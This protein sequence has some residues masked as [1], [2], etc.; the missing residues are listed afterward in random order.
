MNRLLLA[1]ALAAVGCKSGHGLVNL[2]V[3]TQAGVSLTGIDHLTVRITDQTRTPPRQATPFDVGVANGA[4]PP[5]QTIALVFGSDVNGMVAIAVDAVRANGSIAAQASLTTSVSPFH[6]SSLTLSLPGAAV[7]DLGSSGD[8][9]PLDLAVQCPSIVGTNIGKF[10]LRKL[11]MPT[12]RPDWAIDLDGDGRPDNQFG[13]LGGALLAQN[14]N[15]QTS[16]DQQ[17]AAGNDIVLFT[18]RS[19]DSAFQ[20]D[21]CAHVDVQNGRNQANPDFS[22]AGMFTPQPNTF[23][24]P[25]PGTLG[26]GSDPAPVDGGTYAGGVFDSPA[27]PTASPAP[28][29]LSLRLPLS[30]Q[31]YVP[32]VGTHI[33]F[34]DLGNG[35]A[36]GQINGAVS[37]TNVNNIF[38]PNI[39][40]TLTQTIQAMAC[41]P[42][43]LQLKQLFD[44]GGAPDPGCPG[45]TCKNPDGT[46]AAKNDNIISVCEVST[47]Q[48]IR[49]V[50]TPDISVL[51]AN[52]NYHP[53]PNGTKDSMSVGFGFEAATAHF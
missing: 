8:G 17:V 49:N 11:Y 47:N 44:T 36:A 13:S 20:T 18:V 4:I 24:I 2:T 52:G 14:I 34:H 7:G 50:L 48:L 51:D 3:D 53:N 25:F 45:M 22:G 38:I 1:A 9:G 27:P 46:C 32:L 30:W 23:P 21:P 43:C 19:N 40:Q 26:P 31:G 37:Q 10:V 33:H 29:V 6:S 39:A 41:D 28:S 16:T 5:P 12:Q 15:L 35:L 42:S